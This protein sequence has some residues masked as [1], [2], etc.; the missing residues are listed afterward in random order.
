MAN[1]STAKP[2]GTQG[3]GTFSFFSI[4]RY[5]R[6]TLSHMILIGVASGMNSSTHR[7]C[8]LF[9]SLQFHISLSFIDLTFPWDKDA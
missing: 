9:L 3:I 1:F 2:L 4:E 6:H 7:H 5:C 8:L